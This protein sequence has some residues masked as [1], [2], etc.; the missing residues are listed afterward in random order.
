M[1]SR[2]IPLTFIII[3]PA[4]IIILGAFIFLHFT[5][6]QKLSKKLL[7]TTL[8]IFFILLSIFVINQLPFNKIININWRTQD[9][10]RINCEKNAERC[11]IGYAVTCGYWGLWSPI[12]NFKVQIASNC[13]SI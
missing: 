12:M 9:I 5:T 10:D 2:L 7:V 3:L 13:M 8:L 1:E 4:I 11:D 6:K